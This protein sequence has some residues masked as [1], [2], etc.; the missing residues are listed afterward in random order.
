MKIVLRFTIIMLLISVMFSGCS[1][2][3]CS[4]TELQRVASPNGE[5]AAVI[6]ARNCGATTKEAFHVSIMKPDEKLGYSTGN[7]YTSYNRVSLDWNVDHAMTINGSAEGDDVFK[8]KTQY[9]KVGITYQ[10]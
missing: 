4:N 2:D 3:L 10:K 5:Y 7:V 8:T 6:F 1:N 9:K